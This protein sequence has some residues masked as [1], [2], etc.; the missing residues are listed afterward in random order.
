MEYKKINGFWV[1][2]FKRGEKIIEKLTAFVKKENIKSG[3][4]NA[5]GAASSVELAHYDLEKKKYSTKSVNRPLEIVSL[6]GNVAVKGKEAIVH[7]HVAVGTDKMEVY[8]GH[9]KEGIVSA[10]CEMVFKEF[11]KM[12]SKKYDED[13]GLNL[14]K[15]E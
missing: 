7:A 1:I 11:G 3:C 12:I 14:M 4:F 2:V 8:G 9:L 10:T 15:F 5:I 13:T 6:M